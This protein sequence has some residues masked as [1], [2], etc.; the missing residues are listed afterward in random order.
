MTLAIDI[1]SVSTTKTP[2]LINRR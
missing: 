2:A 1:S